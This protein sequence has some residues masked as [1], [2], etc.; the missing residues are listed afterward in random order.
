MFHICNSNF[1]LRLQFVSLF[2]IRNTGGGGGGG[3]EE[4]EEEEEEEEEE[5]AV[6]ERNCD[7][8]SLMKCHRMIICLLLYV[9]SISIHCHYWKFVSLKLKV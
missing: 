9:I 1:K 8:Q 6:L 3:G 4:G 5:E 2:S 7:A